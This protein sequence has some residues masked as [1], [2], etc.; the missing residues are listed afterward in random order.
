MPGFNQ[1]QLANKA[2]NAN[3]VTVMIGDQPIAFAQSVN[4][5]FGF[6]TEALYGVGSAKPQ[7]IQ[8]LKNGPQITITQF[9]LTTI[10]QQLIQSNQTSLASLLGNTKFNIS[11][12]DGINGTTLFTYVGCVSSDFSEDITANQIISDNLTFLAMDVLG[13]SGQSILNGQNALNIT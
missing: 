8:Q 2:R 12:V 9:A 7:E 11:I 6:G 4:H 13:S 10:G 5:T 3:S 1:Q